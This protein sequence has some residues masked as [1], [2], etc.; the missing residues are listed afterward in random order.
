[1]DESIVRVFCQY[2]PAIKGGGI[3]EVSKEAQFLGDWLSFYWPKPQSGSVD[4]S[5]APAV[6]SQDR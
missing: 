1:M 4:I 2:G 6:R 5:Q 3:G